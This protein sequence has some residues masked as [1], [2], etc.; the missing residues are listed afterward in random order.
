M[1]RG[2]LEENIL[3]LLLFFI[4]SLSKVT[5]SAFWR[6]FEWLCNLM[7]TIARSV[8]CATS[9]LFVIR[10]SQI[11][12]GPWR[13]DERCWKSQLEQLSTIS[14]PSSILLYQACFKN[15]FHQVND[16]HD[17]KLISLNQPFTYLKC[18]SKFVDRT[19]Q[20]LVN[21]FIMKSHFKNRISNKFE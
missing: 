3:S 13:H 19:T 4:T 21:L 8:K 17:W 14:F 20:F 10:K 18:L 7:E 6:H 5:V 15:V 1:F 2:Y 16:L 12:L 9:P 11:D